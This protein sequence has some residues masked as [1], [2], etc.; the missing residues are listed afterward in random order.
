MK[1]YRFL[2][3]LVFLGAVAI[4]PIFAQPKPA[5]QTPTSTTPSTTAVPDSKI[6][7]INS[8]LWADEKQGILRLVAASKRVDNEFQPRR[9]ELQ[10]LQQR[11]SQLNDE[12]TKQQAASSVVDPRSLQTKMDQLEQLKKDAQRK[13]EDAQAA[14]N[15]RMQEVLDPIYDDLGKALD[16]FGKSRGIT[17]MLDV[18]KIRPAIL[19]ASDATDV[20]RAFIADFNSKYPATAAV[21]SPK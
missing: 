3:A 15:K 9:T 20:T 7:L 2:A 21:T 11:M 6:G 18:S 16:A 17:L 1:I 12:I 10:Q 14:Y 5:P 4:S 13:Q 8:D 19:M